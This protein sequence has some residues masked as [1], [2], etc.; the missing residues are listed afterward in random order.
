MLRPS[1]IN[2]IFL[3]ALIAFIAWQ[4]SLSFGDNSTAATDTPAPT[5]VEEVL[6]QFVPP[7]GASIQSVSLRGSFNGW[8]ETPMIRREDGSWSVTL[9]LGPGEYQYK[10]FING[11]WAPSMESGPNGAPIDPQANGYSPDGYGGRNAVRIVGG[12][13]AQAPHRDPEALEAQLNTL[14]NSIPDCSIEIYPVILGN[15]GVVRVSQLVAL[16]LERA[17]LRMLRVNEIPFNV[18]AVSDVWTNANVFGDYIANSAIESDYALLG[19]FWRRPNGGVEVRGIMVDA[20]GQPAYVDSHILGQ[21]FDPMKGT[22]VLVQRLRSRLD[23]PDPD[24]E[25]APKGEWA[26][27]WQQESGVPEDDEMIAIERRLDQLRKRQAD[28]DVLVFPI[29]RNDTLDRRSAVGLAALLEEK[30]LCEAHAASNGLFLEMSE[31]PSQLRRMWDMAR[32][33]QSKV[34]DMDLEEEYALYAEYMLNPD[35]QRVFGVNFVLCDKSGDWVVV[36]L[37]NDHH[38]DFQSVAPKTVESCSRLVAKR[39]EGYLANR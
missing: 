28:F 36:D 18:S 24:R 19:E 26:D 2:T 27:F 10:Y 20:K 31:G 16:F 15:E 32:S 34:R 22:Q 37:Q 39:I 4:P 25:D 3:G 35:A 11:E 23:L 13:T 8:G 30:Q 12:G 29:F 1:L 14:K 7:A 21:D 38:D 33:F 5:A 9:K 6:F 17:G